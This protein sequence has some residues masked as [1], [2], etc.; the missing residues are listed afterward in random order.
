M[1]FGNDFGSV[2]EVFGCVLEVLDMFWICFGYTL[3]VLDAYWMCLKCFGIVLEA[4][5]MCIG[6]VLDAS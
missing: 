4:F 2:L 3:E 5:W 1:C 6:Y